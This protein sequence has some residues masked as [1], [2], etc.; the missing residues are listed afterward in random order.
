[1]FRTFRV[2]LVL[3]CSLPLTD[4]ASAEQRRLVIDPGTFAR[5]S[6]DLSGRMEQGGV[7][8]LS[9]IGPTIALLRPD[10][11]SVFAADEPVI[12]HLDFLPATDGVT[13]DMTTLNVRVRKGWFGKN[14]TDV[15]RPYIVGTAIRIP[16]VDFSGYTGDFEFKISVKDLKGRTSTESFRISIRT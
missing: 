9:K 11:N 16:G 14:I 4:T 8:S 10:D 15:V 13:P 6:S 1:M 3:A 2:F 5:L 12:V 7:Q